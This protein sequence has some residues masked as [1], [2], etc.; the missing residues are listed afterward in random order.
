[1]HVPNAASPYIQTSPSLVAYITVSYSRSYPPTT[2]YAA[3]PKID[4]M[5]A[6]FVKLRPP[7]LPFAAPFE[8]RL[9]KTVPQHFPLQYWSRV[10]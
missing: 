7:N 3:V 9:S 10:D 4:T 2:V 6:C 1:M 5:A 8:F